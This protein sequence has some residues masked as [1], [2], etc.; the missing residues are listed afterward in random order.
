MAQENVTAEEM[1]AELEAH[2]EKKVRL[3][4]L[5]TK[6][7]GDGGDKFNF[8]TEWLHQKELGRQARLAW[9]GI[10]IAAIAAIAAVIA[11]APVIR[12][13]F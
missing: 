3:L 4:L 8:V 7:W 6:R 13:W 11:A 9:I 12:S 2:G 5:V 1:T 10:G